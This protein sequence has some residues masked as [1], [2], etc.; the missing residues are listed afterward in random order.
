ML[1]IL[2]RSDKVF[3]PHNNC[4]KNETKTR[5]NT[6]WDKI[7]KKYKLDHAQHRISA[8]WATRVGLELKGNL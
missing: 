1:R 7:S 2:F 3:V 5:K 8:V 4:G 6:Q